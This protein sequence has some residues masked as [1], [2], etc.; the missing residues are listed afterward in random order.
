MVVCALFYSNF[1]FGASSFRSLLILQLLLV[2]NL[3]IFALLSVLEP[4][5]FF[6]SIRQVEISILLFFIFLILVY[7]QYLL[8]G[9]ILT[10][11]VL[12]SVD[13]YLTQIAFFR[14]VTYLLFF[15]SCRPL[16]QREGMTQKL[17][18]AIVFLTFSVTIFN[19]IYRFRET[20]VVQNLLKQNIVGP[21]LYENNLGGFLGITFPLTLSLIYYRIHEVIKNKDSYGESSSRFSAVM[22]SD[23]PFL[24]FVAILTLVASFFVMARAS[25][26]IL[27]GFFAGYLWFFAKRIRSVMLAFF[28]SLFCMAALILLGEFFGWRLILPSYAVPDLWAALYSRFLVS[29]QSLELF[30]MFPFFGTGLATYGTIST[31]V[32]SVL[33]QQV[34]WDYAHNDFVELVTETGFVGVGLLGW[35]LFF[36]FRYAFRVSRRPVSFW[37]RVMTMQALLSLV[38]FGVMELFDYHLKLPSIALLFVMQLAFLVGPAH[39]LEDRRSLK[40]QRFFTGLFFTSCFVLSGFVISATSQNMK[41]EQLLK[42]AKETPLERSHLLREAV[43][44]QPQDSRIWFDLAAELITVSQQVSGEESKALGREALQAMKKTVSL[45]PTFALYWFHLG[46]LEYSFGDE[47]KGLESLRNA[48]AWAPQKLKY[49]NY[50]LKGY[51]RAERAK[52]SPLLVHEKGG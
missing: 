32:V 11:G 16:F 39:P 9:R 30:K 36:L 41:A 20:S 52:A 5:L 42:L 10:H 35:A 40:A 22:N 34:W 37:Q 49:R 27:G 38:C 23:L 24:F 43:K 50:L 46:L 4:D 29:I 1:S 19:T 8:G 48:V 25:A 51:R 2:F 18:L 7:T 47:K 26:I 3:A 21:F 44:V 17:A 33:S 13:P 6:K 45:S 31:K 15:L 14:L 28:L 12:G